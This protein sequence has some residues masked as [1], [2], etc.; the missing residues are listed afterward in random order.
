[1][2][3]SQGLFFQHPIYPGENEVERKTKEDDRRPSSHHTP[4]VKIP[5]KKNPVMI[6]QFLKKCTI[7]AT[8]NVIRMPFYWVKSSRA[9]DR[10]LQ[11]WQHEVTCNHRRQSCASRLHLQ[12]NISKRRSHT[13]RKTLN[14]TTRAESHTEKQLAFAAG[15]AAP[16]SL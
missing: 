2:S 13:V 7:T 3:F 6:T 12:S 1:M 11:F 4:S 8:G 5:M 16:V 15:A 9:Q 14:P 10:G